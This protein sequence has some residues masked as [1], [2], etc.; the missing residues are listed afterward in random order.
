MSRGPTRAGCY[1]R[2]MSEGV[3]LIYETLHGS[4][5]YGLAR[6]GSDIDRNGVMVGPRTWYLGFL[7][8]PEQI[9]HTADHVWFELRK[10]VRLATA[11]NPTI[12]EMLFT[13]PSDHEALHPAGARLLAA[14]DSFLSTR[15]ADTFGRYALS[16][17]GRIQRHRGWLLHPPA[18]A[19]ERA[20]FGLPERSVLPK[21]QLGAAEALIAD[22]RIDEADVTPN[23][24]AV[25]DRERRYRAARKEWQQYQH[26]LSTRNPAR[27]ALEA[28]FGYDTKHAMHLVRLS[29]MA[30]E[31]LERGEVR[32]RRDQDREEL[33]AVRDGAWSYDALIEV[34]DAERER[35]RAA[36]ERSTLPDAPDEEALNALCDELIADV[37]A[38][39]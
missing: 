38:C 9:E 30:V 26:W 19:P 36:K 14:R 37:L 39:P 4:R 10:L 29:R 34:V 23:F 17:L 1:A 33:L 13:D 32:V 12:L 16:Q 24:L 2:V 28:K 8:G 20:D 27:A 11:N 5:A 22:G 7:G 31:I 6:E 15:V 25:L 3:T 35:I 21:D 18:K